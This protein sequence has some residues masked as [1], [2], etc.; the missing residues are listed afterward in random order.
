ML[1]SNLCRG[2]KLWTCSL[3]T[4]FLIIR[5]AFALDNTAAIKLNN[6]GVKALNA[7]DTKSAIEKL[8]A[9][10]RED[11]NYRLARDNLGLVHN[12]YA[13]KLVNSDPQQA[14]KHFHAAL[15][16]SPQNVTTISNLEAT[17]R[18][19]G[20]DPKLFSDR[21]QL[22]DKALSEKDFISARVEYEAALALKE[23]PVVRKKLTGLSNLLLPEGWPINPVVTHEKRAI[24][25]EEIDW[26]PYMA[27][28]QRRIRRTWRPPLD[29]KSPQR[30]PCCVFTL[31]KD[32]T[33]SFVWLAI[34]SGSPAADQAALNA[35]KNA[36]PFAPCP[37]GAPDHTDI[38]FTFQSCPV[39]DGSGG[40]F[41]RF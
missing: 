35:V 19:L 36:A 7:G 4:A 40:T 8:E 39:F 20:K 28:L 26:N 15:F 38:Q 29:E 2:K 27:D 1:S 5:P 9:A 11:P 30:A 41:R 6:E 17:I 23:D 24:I 37:A 13:L 16:Y 10:I 31:Q 12:N 34:S 33:V 32:G 14:M 22:G 21:V 18:T 25:K 3:V